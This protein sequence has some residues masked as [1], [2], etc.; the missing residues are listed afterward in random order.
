MKL[1]ALLAL[2]LCGCSPLAGYVQTAP[3][4]QGAMGRSDVQEAY[5]R[6]I[7]QQRAMQGY[8]KWE[9]Q[10]R[11]QTC[12]QALEGHRCVPYTKEAEEER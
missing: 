6:Y 1:S 4:I 10:P 5:D 12:R 9:Q 2:M 7:S 3:L 11:I 8:P